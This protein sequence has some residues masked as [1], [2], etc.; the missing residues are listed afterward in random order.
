M[1]QAINARNK[2]KEQVIVNTFQHVRCPRQ[3]KEISKLRTIL[4]VIPIT[5]LMSI[6]LL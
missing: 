5:S 1:K 3:W 4:N 6:Q 2:T